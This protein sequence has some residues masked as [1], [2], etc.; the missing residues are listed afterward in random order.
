MHGLQ[1]L[2]PQGTLPVHIIMLLWAL[3]RLQFQARGDLVYSMLGT[4]MAAHPPRTY[5]SVQL[6]A[7]VN[8]CFRMATPPMPVVVNALLDAL[9]NLH[10]VHPGHAALAVYSAAG[11]FVD[12]PDVVTALLPCMSTLVKR[13]AAHIQRDERDMVGQKYLASMMLQAHHATTP[14][15]GTD[16]LLHDGLRSTLVDMV[17]A[18]PTDDA[19]PLRRRL[20]VKDMQLLHESV[21]Q[22]GW[23]DEVQT[24]VTLLPGVGP[25][26]VL[27]TLPDGRVIAFDVLRRSHVFVNARNTLVGQLAF[28]QVLMSTRAA[29]PLVLVPALQLWG[30]SRQGEVTEL[31]QQLVLQHPT[32]REVVRSAALLTA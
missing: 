15:G 4:M 24:E 30:A 9:G 17:N 19:R 13:F 21:L 18:A 28:R 25:V 2:D 5:A 14:P 31:L 16:G 8:A 12:D 1:R 26:D 10:Y 3:S 22:L 11:M 27:G 23:F 29:C 6:A 7:L 32:A 20:S